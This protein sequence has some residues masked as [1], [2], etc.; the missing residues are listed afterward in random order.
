MAFFGFHSSFLSLLFPS[1][2]CFI[3]T[4]CN[5]I[6]ASHQSPHTFQPYPSPIPPSNINVVNITKPLLGTNHFMGS[7]RHRVISVVHDQISTWQPLPSYRVTFSI[8][9]YFFFF[10]FC[11]CFL[12]SIFKSLSILSFPGPRLFK[13]TYPFSS[14]KLLPPLFQ[15]ISVL[16]KFPPKEKLIFH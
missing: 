7:I 9:F 5:K 15:F 13:L 16:Q 12:F 6:W 11:F 2:I 10:C 14:L 3:K 1:C 8:F 4:Q